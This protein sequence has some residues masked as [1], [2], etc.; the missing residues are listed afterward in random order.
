ME[1]GSKEM[2]RKCLQNQ[3]TNK[4]RAPERGGLWEQVLAGR[5]H[6]GKQL[7][8]SQTR[9]PGLPGGLPLTWPHIRTLSRLGLW[10]VTSLM[11]PPGR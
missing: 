8:V 9:K 2:I 5:G 1:A 3:R 4:T 11:L 10:A 7:L 6:L